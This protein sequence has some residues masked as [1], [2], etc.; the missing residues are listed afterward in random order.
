M[1]IL[2][3]ILFSQ[4]IH[5]ALNRILVSL[6]EFGVKAY[7]LQIEN[8][9]NSGDLTMRDYCDGQHFKSHPLNAITSKWLQVCKKHNVKRIV[10]AL[11][12]HR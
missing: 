2:E 9:H 1:E 5:C 6:I 8:G 3:H 7:C 12:M 4:L 11:I 10:T